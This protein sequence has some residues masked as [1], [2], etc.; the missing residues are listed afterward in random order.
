MQEKSRDSISKNQLKSHKRCSCKGR[1]TR[2]QESGEIVIKGRVTS[3][4]LSSKKNRQ[5]DQINI[6]DLADSYDS[7]QEA[8]SNQSKMGLVKEEPITLLEQVIE[9]DLNPSKTEKDPVLKNKTKFF[10][11]MMS[12]L[13]Q[14]I[15]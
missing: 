11:K 6:N 4:N 7:I 8:S 13:K 2:I 14:F 10:K 1:P 9:K 3:M 5:S 15:R 12:W